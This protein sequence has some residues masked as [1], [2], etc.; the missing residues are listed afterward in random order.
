[1][2]NSHD[3]VFQREDFDSVD[4]DVEVVDV[5]VNETNIE[6][7]DGNPNI[8]HLK[9]VIDGRD[10]PTD[11][12]P[13]EE[14][15]IRP[16]PPPSLFRQG[17]NPLGGI[18]VPN[19]TPMYGVTPSLIRSTVLLSDSS[20]SINKRKIVNTVI[21]RKSSGGVSTLVEIA[22]AFGEAI[23]TEMKEMTS[24]TKETESNKLEVK[25]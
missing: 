7:L 17:S 6:G 23:A 16:A 1:L 10:L 11:C 20:H 22:K 3:K 9:R 19:G 12:D 14:S 5:S 21:R 15:P 13:L 2:L 25:L 24:V 4:D 18:G 8:N